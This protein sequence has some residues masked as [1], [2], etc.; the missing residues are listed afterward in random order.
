MNALIA[1]TAAKLRKSLPKRAPQ[2]AIVLGSGFN[3]L[4]RQIEILAE[5]RYEALPG[6]LAPSVP[7]HSGRL[8]LG[9]VGGFDL[10][11]LCGR[12]HFYEG[13]SLSQ[14]T[15]PIRVL[16][17]IGVQ[18]LVLTNAAGGI[19]PK[20]RPG[21]LMCVTDHINF[22]GANPLREAGT[23]QSPAFVDLSEVYDP[24]LLRL[25]RAAARSAKVRLH[26]GIYIAVSGPSYE[27]P[28]EIEAF[29][30]LGADAVG[31]ST[32][33][34]AIVARHC[35]MRVA[36]LSCITNL[37]AGQSKTPI[38]HAEVLAAGEKA[39]CDISRLV[40]GFVE[41]FSRTL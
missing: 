40:I 41:L 19:N 23:I 30:R 38:R 18:T 13:H 14:I 31:M 16:A 12:S 7:G 20:L 29:A 37:A 11:L 3:A 39:Q 5:I 27:T 2:L 4:A 9:Q 21:D 22:M 36:A 34:E 15:F 32:V 25:F 1:K 24:A 8:L 10:L 26:R 6:F 17:A 33:P 28:A 35:G